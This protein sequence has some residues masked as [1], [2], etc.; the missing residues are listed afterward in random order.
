M[1][2]KT[3]GHYR[4]GQ[5]ATSCPGD[6][7]SNAL[8]NCWALQVRPPSLSTCHQLPWQVELLLP[9]IPQI[10]WLVS[11]NGNCTRP[12]NAS[13]MP[14][15]PDQGCRFTQLDVVSTFL[16]GRD[17]FPGLISEQRRAV[18]LGDLRQDLQELGT[19]SLGCEEV[20]APTVLCRNLLL[21]T[22]PT[23]H[24]SSIRIIRI[25]VQ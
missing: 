23:V 1:P 24:C 3:A 22:A 4:S 15:P 13:S 18:I 25:R 8:Q 9:Q 17:N 7:S 14:F 20:L 6:R 16:D 5:H 2:C 21:G 19:F 11:P 12:C 10:H